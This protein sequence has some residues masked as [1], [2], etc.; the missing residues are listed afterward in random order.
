MQ[1]W[2][3]KWLITRQSRR[4]CK[5][6]FN[7]IAVVIHADQKLFLDQPVLYELAQVSQRGGTVPLPQTVRLALVHEEIHR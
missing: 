2:W 1:A 7:F 5:L 6:Q 3:A 4:F